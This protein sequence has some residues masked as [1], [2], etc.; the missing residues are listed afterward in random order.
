MPTTFLSEAA[1]AASIGLINSF[2]NLGG[3]VGPYVVGFL[4]DRTG[5][6]AAG[7]VYLGAMALVGSAMI[8]SVRA[9]RKSKDAPVT[10]TIIR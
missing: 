9:A 10:A 2:G 5:T 8:L 3:F 6:Y 1:A 4:T 7:I